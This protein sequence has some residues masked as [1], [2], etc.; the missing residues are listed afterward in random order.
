MA[1]RRER[2]MARSPSPPFWRIIIARRSSRETWLVQKV[3]RSCERRASSNSN[4]REV[5]AAVI[6]P[7]LMS[8]STRIGTVMAAC[9]FRSAASRPTSAVAASTAID[10]ASAPDHHRKSSSIPSTRQ[11]MALLFPLP[12]GPINPTPPR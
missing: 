10:R 1:N 11:A 6:T 12:D 4:N 5:H 8:S 2:A 9:H 7:W 3:G